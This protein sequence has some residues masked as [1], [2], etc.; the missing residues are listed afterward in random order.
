M[1]K[2]A[3]DQELPV[4]AI[5]QE[6]AFPLLVGRRTLANVNDHVQNG[7]GNDA[8]QLGLG[9]LAP[10]EVEAPQY[11]GLG[12]ERLVVLHEIKVDP[13]RLEVAVGVGFFEE[14]PPVAENGRGD[15][16]HVLQI[17]VFND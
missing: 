1:G 17:G 14:A 16:L 2:A 3:R 12:R 13:G 5:G 7:P 8:D 11:A 4:V 6:V 15:Q 9:G 10:L